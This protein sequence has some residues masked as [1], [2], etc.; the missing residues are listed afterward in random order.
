MTS[1][2]CD[3]EHHLAPPGL[4]QQPIPWSC[5]FLHSPTID[6]NSAASDPF[7]YKSDHVTSLLKISNS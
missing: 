3:P 2:C 5:V 6:F 1:M 4:L 7:K